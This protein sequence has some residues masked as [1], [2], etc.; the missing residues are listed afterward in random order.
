VLAQL[1]TELRR[2][3][4]V[5][6]DNLFAVD[7]ADRLILDTAAEAL[8][9]ADP[10]TVV[11][12][13]DNY[14]ALTLGAAVG[15]GARDVRVFQDLITGEQALRHNAEVAGLLGG[16]RQGELDP[17][18]LAG[19]R[20]V[21]MRLP[22]SLDELRELADAVA[23][24]ADPEVLVFAGGRDKHITPAMNH[25]LAEMFASVRPTRGRQKSRVLAVAGPKSVGPPPFPVRAELT[26]LGTTVVAYGAAFAGAK[27]DI[28]TRYLLT[29]RPQML[30]TATEAVDL[31]CGTGILAVEL[32]RARPDLR[33]T[34]TD[35]SSGAVASARATAE[36]NDVGDR[37]EVV[38]SDA[39]SGFPASS[40]DLI[41]CNPPFHA[42]ASVHTGIASKMFAAAGRVLRSSGELWTVYNTHLGYRGALA[43][44]VGPT[45][46]QGRNRKFTV[47]RSVR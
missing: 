46:V 21:L 32:A 45:T 7:A 20:V 9:N 23:R 31:G 30:P 27:L 35:R 33:V 17:Q 3:P 6:A 4:D 18:L 47:T 10:G 44:F 19:A 8:T 28:G 14:G 22:R 15:Y 43:R 36:A 24:W 37:V 12:L 42:G 2:Y 1:F 26:E 41:V 16:Y 38:R 11:V 25:V 40:A 5:E 29:F 39:M 34:A 13:N